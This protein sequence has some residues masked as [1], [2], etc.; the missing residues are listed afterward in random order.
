LLTVVERHGNLKLLIPYVFPEALGSYIYFFIHTCTG[1]HSFMADGAAGMGSY[2]PKLPSQHAST[3]S[4]YATIQY[5]GSLPML[6]AAFVSNVFDQPEMS[7]TNRLL[8]LFGEL[9]GGV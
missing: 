9:T 4:T 6:L 7:N 5:I 3:I 1:K 8:L 2:I